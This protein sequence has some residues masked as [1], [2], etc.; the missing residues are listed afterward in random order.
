MFHSQRSRLRRKIDKSNN[1][2][3]KIFLITNSPEEI[4]SISDIEHIEAY[5]NT[6]IYIRRAL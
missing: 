1:L 2:I 3:S 4:L 5:R 6:N